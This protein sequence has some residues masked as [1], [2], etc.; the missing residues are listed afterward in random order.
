MFFNPFRSARAGQR[1]GRTH[2]GHGLVL[3]RLEDRTVP[4]RGIDFT[5]IQ[6]S[7]S[8][9]FPPDS[10]GDV[11]FTQI[12]AATNGRI[13]VFDKG[14]NPSGFTETLDTFFQTVTSDPH[15]RFDRLSGRWF[16]TA[17]DASVDVNN[18][19]LIAVSTGPTITG[20][21]SFHYFSFRQDQVGPT[22]N[23]DTGKFADFDTLG[24]DKF[25]L[26]IGA[27]MI[28]GTEDTSSGFVINKAN[29]LHDTLTVT[30]FRQLGT[31]SGGIDV[32]QGVNN[33]DPAATE[34][35]FIGVDSAAYGKLNMIRISNPGGVPTASQNLSVTVPATTFPIG[36]LQQAPGGGAAPVRLDP[37]GDRLFAAAIHRD[38]LTGTVSLWTAHNIE[39]NERGEGAVGGGRNGA[40]WYQIGNLTGAPTLLQSGTLFDPF[41]APRGYIFPSVAMNG[42]GNMVIAS[43]TAGFNAT[44]GVAYAEHLASDPLG[45]TEVPTFIP[46]PTATYKGGV[47]P[48]EGGL[49][50]V[51][52]WG[53]YSQTVV[54][55]SDDMTMWTFQEYSMEDGTWGMLCAQIRAPGSARP[56][57]AGRAV[58]QGET[59]I[60]V[61]IT[62]APP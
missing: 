50:N 19:I 13:K 7:E 14:G 35:Y 46:L 32:P 42:Q 36:Q 33:D 3:E 45:S 4:S 38:K 47:M 12:L 9:S 17:I 18:R 34:G 5:A 52:R 40:R 23:A 55:P 59:N 58:F 53:D 48:S 37:V 28:G 24:V 2:P 54:D 10:V 16:V 29:L 15:V 61:V 51:T 6:Y 62:G 43:T 26:Y 20:H 22:P 39:V 21:N 11:S 25:A 30:P 27:V 60:N 57:S 56:A 8:Q 49:A 1:T 31:A 44:P 41:G